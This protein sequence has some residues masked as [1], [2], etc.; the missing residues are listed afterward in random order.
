MTLKQVGVKLEGE[1]ALCNGCLQVT[2]SRKPIKLYTT[3]RAVK[4]GG[5]VFVD[6]GWKICTVLKGKEANDHCPG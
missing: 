4:P 2:R 5:R 6:L 1:L 3:T